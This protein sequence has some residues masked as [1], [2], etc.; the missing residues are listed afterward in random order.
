MRIA[1]IGPVADEETLLRFPAAFSPAGVRWN[2]GF[3]RAL[4]AEDVDVRIVYHL[5]QPAWPRGP[6]W[7]SSYRLPKG[8]NGDS[9]P[10]YWNVRG[11]RPKSL[12]KGYGQVIRRWVAEGW[13]PDCVVSYNAGPQNVAT[14]RAL[15]PKFGVP[16]IVLLADADADALSAA[17]CIQQG[18]RGVVHLSWKAFEAQRSGSRLH[19]DGGID[20]CRAAPNLTVRTKNIVYSGA[21]YP[22]A[23]ADFLVRAFHRLK[24]PEARLHLTG[25]GAD[26]GFKALVQ[27]DSRITLHGLVSEAKLNE[28]CGGA[29]LFVNPRPSRFP[30]NAENFPSKLL[31]YLSWAR[32]VISTMTPGVHPEYR[33][34]LTVLEHE[35]EE[36]LAQAMADVLSW[37][38]SRYMAQTQKIAAWMSGNR[39]WS[40]QARRFL[41]WLP[42]TK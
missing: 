20:Y 41:N 11:L 32:P 5:A 37:P 2:G 19:L 28:V 10:G 6:F 4:G 23:G 25:K 1:W 3:V 9:W 33:E 17:E 38:D 30:E 35:T 27:A 14:A 42:I 7:V 40:S 31:E 26:A 39:L 22:V 34:V 13:K 8:G 21:L 12:A 36:A 15:N 29:G 24:D 18:A 16:W